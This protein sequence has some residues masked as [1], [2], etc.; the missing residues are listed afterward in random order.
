MYSKKELI[1]SENKPT[2]MQAIKAAQA[3][4]PKLSPE[5]AATIQQ[6]KKTPKSQVTTDQHTTKTTGRSR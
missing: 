6:T 2:F 5:T 4:T 3:L 1:M